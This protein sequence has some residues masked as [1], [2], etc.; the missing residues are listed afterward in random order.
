MEVRPHQ[1]TKAGG[2]FGMPRVK[3]VGAS[4]IPELAEL[5]RPGIAA[6]H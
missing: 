1:F 6:M 4:I 5:N 3:A 2:G